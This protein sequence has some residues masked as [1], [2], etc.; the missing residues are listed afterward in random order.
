MAIPL[1]DRTCCV[2]DCLF[3]DPFRSEL[4][5]ALVDL[6]SENIPFCENQTPEGM[7]R[8]RFAIVKLVAS[9]NRNLDSSLD[10]AQTDWRDL[11]MSAGFGYDSNQHNDWYD[12]TVAD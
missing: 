10:L 2:L 1:S 9:D 4:H 5:A 6:V 12:R 11:L 3:D 8:I 7:E